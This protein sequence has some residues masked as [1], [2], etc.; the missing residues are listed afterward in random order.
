VIFELLSDST[1]QVARRERKRIYEQVFRTPEYFLFDRSASS[2]RG[3]G[4]SPRY[5]PMIPGEA[6]R[7]TSVQLGAVGDELRLFTRDGELVRKPDEAALEAERRAAAEHE[8]RGRTRACGCRARPCRCGERAGR[9]C[10][11]G[12]C[13]ASRLARTNRSA[14]KTEARMRY[15][16]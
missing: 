11:A 12:A 8:C 2:C 15:D 3:S 5:E 14:G 6:G 13:Q 4:C 7:L 10:R 1:S 16:L 9:C